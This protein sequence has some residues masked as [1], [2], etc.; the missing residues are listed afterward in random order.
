[1]SKLEKLE[2]L[3]KAEETKENPSVVKTFADKMT[4]TNEEELTPAR[5]PTWV[6]NPDSQ[7]AEWTNMIFRQLWPHL[8]EFLKQTLKT[9]EDDPVLRERLSGYHIRSLTF[10]DF[11]L[12]R[13]PPKI[14][15]VKVHKSVH[16]DE[17]IV[18]VNLQYAG[19]LCINMEVVLDSYIRFVPPAR[20]SIMD[21]H[22]E[23]TLRF[24]FQ[25]PPL[26]LDLNFLWNISE[27]TCV[28]F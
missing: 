18:D 11:S 26:H 9:V 19:D 13:I 2:K 3:S 24:E 21:M 4:E 20:A 16:R 23:G 17:I 27:F 12:G 22:F 8:E 7:R 15:G 25:L 28:P 10:P 14:E 1:M 6:Y 5:L